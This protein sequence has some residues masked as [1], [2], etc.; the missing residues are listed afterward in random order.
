M[1][2]PGFIYGFNVKTNFCIKIAQC[3]N[4]INY[5]IHNWPLQPSSQDYGLASHT[6]HVVCVNFIREWR[7]LQFN[8]DSERQIFEKLFH[9][10]FNL[11]SEFL[12]EMCWEEVAEEIF[13]IYHF[14]FFF[15][16]WL[17][18]VRI[19]AFSSNKPTHYTTATSFCL[20][21]LG[22]FA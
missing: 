10:R 21:Y 8:V 11:L 19:Q 13:F 2:K 20:H 17:T 6:T 1:V 12:P 16:W 4:T 7:N 9:G 5:S 22:V 14:F 15:F 3:E 18:C